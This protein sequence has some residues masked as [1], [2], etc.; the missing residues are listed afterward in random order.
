[1]RT[2]ACVRPQTGSPRTTVKEMER[3]IT[4]FQLLWTAFIIFIV[5]LISQNVSDSPKTRK[6]KVYIALAMTIL[7]T[8]LALGI[9]FIFGGPED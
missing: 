3:K 9:V 8:F 6:E 2:W 5:S 7:F 4:W 1:M